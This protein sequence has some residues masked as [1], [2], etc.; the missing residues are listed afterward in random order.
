MTVYAPQA[1][2]KPAQSGGCGCG[3]GGA[4]GCESRCCELECLVRPRFFCGQVLT[5]ADLGAAVD[6]ARNRFSLARYRHGWGIVCGLDVTCTGRGTRGDCCPG[7]G[8]E[9]GPTV[10]VSPGYAIDCCGNDLVVCQ[11]I[12]VD[13]G[14]ACRPGDDPCNPTPPK[15]AG[16]AK[17]LDILDEDKKDVDC[18]RSLRE[19]LFTATLR[20]RY[21]EDLASG[22]PAMFRSGCSDLGACEYSRVLEHPCVHV[23]VTPTDCDEDT[24]WRSWRDDFVE[25]REHAKREI[26]LA[27]RGGTE[28]VL[29][30]LRRHPPYKFCFLKDLVCCFRDRA[31][32]QTD[33]R[34]AYDLFA[35]KGGDWR[36]TIFF[37]LYLDWYLRQFECGCWSCKPDRGVPLARLLMQ[38]VRRQGDVFCRVIMID[39]SYPHR[40]PIHKD[41]CR[42]IPRGAVDLAPYL[43]QSPTYA[44]EQLRTQGVLVT[45]SDRDDPRELLRLIDGGNLWLDPSEVRGLDAYIIRDPFDCERIIGFDTPGK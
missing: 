31:A 3:C 19:G 4:C 21:R 18:W 9:S 13:L 40:R 41:P 32:E 25:K 27:M 11:P 43:W 14:E 1:E 5:D 15:A 20:L 36:I 38:R 45:R 22:Q 24:D 23:D 7:Q 29:K 28:D 16:K 44:R 37:W 8:P 33:Q 42:P 26:E 6:W 10:Y 35:L 39:G 17:A 12:A 34:G 30:Y 2:T